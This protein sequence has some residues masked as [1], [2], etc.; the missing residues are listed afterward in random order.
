MAFVDLSGYDVTNII[1]E[2]LT[3]DPNASFV[4]RAKRPTD[5]ADFNAY[6]G[7]FFSGRHEAAELTV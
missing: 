2:A 7:E 6:V 5:P 3:A 4:V 1:T